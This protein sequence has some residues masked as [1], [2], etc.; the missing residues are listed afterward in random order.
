MIPLPHSFHVLALLLLQHCWYMKT[1]TVEI[2]FRSFI[3]Y[4]LS[5]P[6]CISSLNKRIHH[7]IFV[8]LIRG[9]LHALFTI[10]G[11]MPLCISVEIM[12]AELFD[13]SPRADHPSKPMAK[14]EHANLSL[15]ST[16]CRSNKFYLLDGYMLKPRYFLR[17][18]LACAL[19]TMYLLVLWATG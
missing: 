2:G 15:K 10:R 9:E 14:Q 11:T 8:I 5:N 4:Q 17:H 3:T 1:A 13:I 18:L 7:K 19:L 16:V 6:F 12:S